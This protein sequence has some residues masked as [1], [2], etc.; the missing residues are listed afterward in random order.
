MRA[1]VKLLLKIFLCTAV[2]FGAFMGLFLGGFVALAASRPGPGWAWV[3]VGVGVGSGV[4]AGLFFGALM[5][6]FAGGWH[7]LAVR[8]LG[9]PLTE[10]TLAV[11]QRR[12]LTLDL[13]FDEAFSLCTAAVRRLPRA[14]VSEDTDYNTGVILAVKGVSWRSWGEKIRFDLTGRDGGRAAVAVECRPALATTLVDY[15]AC[16][17]DMDALVGFLLAHDA[18]GPDRPPRPAGDEACE[19][20]RAADGP[21]DDDPGIVR[22]P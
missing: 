21:E 8:R 18:D 15:G 10:E 4:A 7:I 20:V 19:G 2:P 3:A 12:A 22:A 9:F 16:L 17:R 13:P 6:L 5:A 1:S 11:R 14:Y